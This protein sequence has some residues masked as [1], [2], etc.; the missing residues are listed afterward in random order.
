MRAVFHLLTILKNVVE[1]E[2]I[3]TCHIRLLNCWT[4][5]EDM[6]KGSLIDNIKWFTIIKHA[7]ESLS[8][9][10]L[11]LLVSQVPDGILQRGRLLSY[12]RIR[13]SN[14]HIENKSCGLF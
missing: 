4:P 3:N 12:G 6:L 7:Q 1:L 11:R 9:A 5:V 8:S 13:T 14:P 10:F 2:L